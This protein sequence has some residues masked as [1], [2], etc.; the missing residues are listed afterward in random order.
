VVSEETFDIFSG[1]PEE[2]GWRV[3]TVEDFA[4]AR[5]RLG[6]IAVEKP[7]KYFLFSDSDQSVLTR[8]DTLSRNMIER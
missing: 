1:A 2:H 5:Q 7:G 3:E 8:V 4:S 6:Q